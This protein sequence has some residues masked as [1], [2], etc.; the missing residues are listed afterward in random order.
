MA[1]HSY[2]MDNVRFTRRVALTDTRFVA[3]YPCVQHWP[4]L[5]SWIPMNETGSARK[6]KLCV[7]VCVFCRQSL[8]GENALHNSLCWQLILEGLP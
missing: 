3:S 7:C 8:F 1:A 4:P 5:M 6:R 2:V